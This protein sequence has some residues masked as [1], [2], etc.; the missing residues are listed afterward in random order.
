[1]PTT[2][3]AA[4]LRRL[5]D[6]TQR[7][8]SPSSSMI[9][10]P[11]EFVGRLVIVGRL[12]VAQLLD[13]ATQFA[14]LLS[15]AR[16]LPDEA[17]VL[18]EERLQERRVVGFPRRRGR[19]DEARRGHVVAVA[20]VESRVARQ[21]DGVAVGRRGACGRPVVALALGRA[22]GGPALDRGLAGLDLESDFPEWSRIFSRAGT[23]AEFCGFVD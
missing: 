12:V 21:R 7:V 19:A 20:A 4:R 16:D 22:R 2:S 11:V 13:L 17:R 14:V 9:F 18:V 1:M 8:D 10:R 15:E 5:G 23:I 6:T 3:G